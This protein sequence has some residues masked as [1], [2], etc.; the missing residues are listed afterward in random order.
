MA[1]S[2]QD[3]CITL[4]EQWVQNHVQPRCGNFDL[5]GNGGSVIVRGLVVSAGVPDVTGDE[6]AAGLLRA[7]GMKGDDARPGCLHRPIKRAEIRRENGRVVIDTTA[8]VV[9]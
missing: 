1:V 6:V 8:E 3:L 7:L 9:R 5:L 4:A 2:L